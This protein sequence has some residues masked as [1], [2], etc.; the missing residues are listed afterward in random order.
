MVRL[1][2]DESAIEKSSC[3]NE[4]ALDRHPGTLEE[5]TTV[6]VSTVFPSCGETRQLS[7]LTIHIFAVLPR[8]ELLVRLHFTIHDLVTLAYDHR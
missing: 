1:E 2:H 5:A 7:E 4:K 6:P 3:V 8:S